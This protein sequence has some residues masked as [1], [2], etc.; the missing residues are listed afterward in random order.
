VTSTSWTAIQRTTS[1]S[2]SKTQSLLEP[3]DGAK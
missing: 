2:S 3:R 1:G